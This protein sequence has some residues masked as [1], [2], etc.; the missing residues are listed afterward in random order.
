MRVSVVIP[1]LNEA[2]NIGRLVEETYA[3]VPAEML[4]EVI[5][6]DDC[7]ED[8]TGAEVK[9]LIARGTLPGLRYL[10]HGA[11][12]GQSAAMRTGILAATSPVIATMDGDGQN[13]PADI[14]RL[15]GRLAAPG[16][17]GPALVGGIRTDR[18]AEGSKRIASRFANWLR[19]RVLKDDCPDTGCGIK[20]YWREAFLRLPYFTSM[21]RY[22]PALFLSY[23][24]E[25]AYEPV[26]DRPRVAGK[27]KYTNL[28]RALVGV[29]DLVG[30][31]WLRRRTTVPAIIED[32]PEGR[33]VSDLSSRLRRVDG[34]R[35]SGGIDKP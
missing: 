32:L 27:S 16:S 15:I 6:V 8:T 14:S 25:V 11:R 29:Y 10:R 4:G 5:V 26:N 24:H 31:A 20:A 17:K 34:P 19:D 7:S 28:G 12:S 30:V 22:L 3:V 35:R 23:G 33:Q 21:H 13:D 2:G 1:A 9:T 18:K